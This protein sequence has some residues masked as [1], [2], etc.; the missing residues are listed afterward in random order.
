MSFR[1]N[2]LKSL[3][4]GFTEQLHGGYLSQSHHGIALRFL[5]S[6]NFSFEDS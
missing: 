5:D 4:D 2:L 3:G 1:A 6:G